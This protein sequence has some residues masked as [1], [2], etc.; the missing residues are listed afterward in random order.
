MSQVL[1]VLDQ[2]NSFMT[3]LG[4]FERDHGLHRLGLHRLAH[5]RQVD[6]ECRSLT[7]FTV[8]PDVTFT[9]LDNAIN[10]GKS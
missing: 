5:P 4:W 8:D 6:L 9:L 7:S 10:S 3:L 2:Q 1:F